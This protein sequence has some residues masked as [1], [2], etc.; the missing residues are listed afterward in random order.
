MKNILSTLVIAITLTSAFLTSCLHRQNEHSNIDNFYKEKGEWDSGRIPL[1]KPYEAV[2]TSKELGWFINLEGRDGDT[3]LPNINKVTVSQGIIFLYNTKTVLHGVEVKE[4][5]HVIIPNKQIEKGFA[6]YKEYVKYLNQL[7][8]KVEPKL[9][10]INLV[11][12]YFENHDLMN[13]N[14]VENP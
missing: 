3:G 10:D 11:A 8:I 7:G 2:I 9:H 12:Q 13:W 4:A 6:T 1:I 14:E 5:W